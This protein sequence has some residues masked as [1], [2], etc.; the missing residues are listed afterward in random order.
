M[1]PYDLY[2]NATIVYIKECKYTDAESQKC[3]MLSDSDD[4][5]ILRG[6]RRH[7]QVYGRK[8]FL[9]K[10]RVTKK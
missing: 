6:K 9:T 2:S 7:Q 4:D 5:H 8:I 3:S 10:L 1:G